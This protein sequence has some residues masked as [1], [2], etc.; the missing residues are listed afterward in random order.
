MKMKKESERHI[1]TNKDF[2]DDKTKMLE[3]SVAKLKAE[4]ETAK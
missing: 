2:A 1:E 4:I 3:D